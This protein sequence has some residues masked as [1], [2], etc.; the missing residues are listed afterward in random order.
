MVSA[1]A[2][3]RNGTSQR[4]HG[5][6]EKRRRHAREH[7]IAGRF[8]CDFSH[9]RL[10]CTVRA[11]NSLL[12]YSLHFTISIHTLVDRMVQGARDGPCRSPAGERRIPK[13]GC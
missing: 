10:P 2:E 13:S 7:G 3:G 1:F 9:G 12:T 11:L 8:C 5:V 4:S 6:Y